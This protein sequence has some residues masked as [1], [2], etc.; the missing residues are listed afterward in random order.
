PFAGPF[1]A[2]LFAEVLEHLN[3]HPVPTLRKLASAL[4]ASG[5]LYLSTPDARFHGRIHTYHRSVAAMPLPRADVA[6]MDTHVYIYD[7]RELRSVLDD[8]GLAVTRFDHAPGWAGYRHFNAV[9]V[10]R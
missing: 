8:A 10:R 9:C 1:D 3:F 6:A 5:R 2:I 7:E 4:T